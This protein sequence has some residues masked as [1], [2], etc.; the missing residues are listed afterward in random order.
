MDEL[1]RRAADSGMTGAWRLGEL[2]PRELRTELAALAARRREDLERA[3]LQ[4]WLT[5]RYVL[6]AMHAPRR[7]P[8]R[9]DGLRRDLR[10]MSDE[11][12]KRAFIRLAQRRRG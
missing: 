5:G 4:A 10:P 2:T 11:E 7:F 8:R 9:P 1:I 12:M 6:T 3:D